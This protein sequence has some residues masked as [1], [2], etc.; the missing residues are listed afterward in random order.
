[1]KKELNILLS[2]SGFMFFAGG[3]FGPLYAIFVEQIGGDLLT[4][5]SAYSVFAVSAGLL[6]YVISK[7]EDR[8]GHI[9][10]FVFLG[11]II[12]AIGYIGYLFVK[13]PWHLFLLQIVFGLGQAIGAPA[14]DGLYS[15]L[16]DHGRYVSQWGV[17]ESMT[18]IVTGI[19]AVIGGFIAA[20]FGFNTLFIIMA[21]LSGIGALIAA[22][23]ISRV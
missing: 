14:Y 15:Q 21:V 8:Q 1:M 5:G 4:A 7:W 12:S 17:W 18:W 23:L 13:E 11:Y 22:R 20:I 10:F 16:M 19:G 2:A 9:P 6:I 3:L